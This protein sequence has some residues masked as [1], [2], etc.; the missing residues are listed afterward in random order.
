MNR[1]LLH[2]FASPQ[3]TQDSNEQELLHVDLKSCSLTGKFHLIPSPYQTSALWWE[4]CVAPLNPPTKAWSL[5]V[6]HMRG[7]DSG[8]LPPMGNQVFLPVGRAMRV[9]QTGLPRDARGPHVHR[10]LCTFLGPD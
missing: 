2:C 9:E 8:S 6:F 5:G 4:V 3:N 7:K 10:D 1:E